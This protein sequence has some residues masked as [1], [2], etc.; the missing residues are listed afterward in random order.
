MVSLA[1]GAKKKPVY[2]N[3]KDW[4]GIRVI[5]PDG[6]IHMNS[7]EAVVVME[8]APVFFTLLGIDAQ[9]QMLGRFRQALNALQNPM[10]IVISTEQVDLSDYLGRMREHRAKRPQLAAFIEAQIRHVERYQK[11]GITRKRYYLVVSGYLSERAMTDRTNQTATAFGSAGFKVTRLGF[12]DTVKALAIAFGANPVPGNPSDQ[13]AASTLHRINH[14]HPTAKATKNAKKPMDAKRKNQGPS[15]DLDLD[16]GEEIETPLADVAIYPHDL[17]A[18]ALVDPQTRY[19][20]LGGHVAATLRCM[21]YPREVQNGILEM[22]YQSSFD[23][24]IAMHF[25]P[26]PNHKVMAELN[27]QLQNIS[28]TINDAYHRGR[29]ANAYDEVALEEVRQQRALIANNE[30]KMFHFNL[31]VTVFADSPGELASNIKSLMT[32]LNGIGFG[33][34]NCVLEQEPAFRASL[35]L[36][37]LPVSYPR[38][39]DSISLSTFLPFTAV[40][41]VHLTGNYIGPNL[42]TGGPVLL[43]QR[44]F[45][46]GH[47]VVVAPTG[48]G[49]T[50][51]IKIVSA[52]SLF[53]GMALWIIDPSP[54]IDYERYTR[55]LQGEY[56][57]LGIGSDHCINPCAIELPV[58]RSKLEDEFTKPVT[59]KVAF[60]KDLVELMISEVGDQ[61]GIRERA[62][63]EKALRTMYAEREM[64]DDWD[65]IL[66]PSSIHSVYLDPES[67]EMPTLSDLMR[68]LREG[69]PG[70]FE[71]NDTARDLADR[72]EPFVN[73]VYSVFNGET[74]VNVDAKMI[75][76][77]IHKLANVSEHLQR[78]AYAVIGEF[79]RGRMA[80][81]LDR[82]NLVVDEAHIMYRNE[83]TARLLDQLFRMSR[84]L[85][86]MVTIITQSITD[87]IGDPD[88]GQD[89]PGSRYARS[90][91]Q[92]SYINYIGHHDKANEI[93]H[94]VKIFDLSEA[95]VDFLRNAIPGDLLLIAGTQHALVHVD[96]PPEIYRIVTT[97]PEEV[98]QIIEE[99][100]AMGIVD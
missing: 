31:F 29:P 12:D 74:N 54:P 18:P 63:L 28:S 48:S 90:A 72:M 86:G 21:I 23:M 15:D 5:D 34:H 94:L 88:L 100:R 73:G 68:I 83:F 64:N 6:T 40:D 82:K 66:E 71:A 42:V 49:K 46:A 91:L 57:V 98:A 76:F 20:D 70:H 2:S 59:A 65:S 67:K 75:T 80:A 95:E 96:T 13:I 4:L 52:Q 36:G 79:L 10:E 77:N 24:R 60:L 3:T 85:G 39:A 87:M 56:I 61:L 14:P 32:D 47:Q 69:S 51:M 17:M 43:D 53:A 38:N 78:V 35:P 30:A 44:L 92:N 97:N 19:L 22:L 37:L 89:I 58:D 55:R 62:L 50:M 81:T 26:I 1:L 8:V 45:P 16:L 41:L 84:R 27:S 7:G 93:K 25:D 99:E 33:F 11:A 9:D